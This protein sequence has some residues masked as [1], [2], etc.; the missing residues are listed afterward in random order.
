MAPA[1]VLIGH[2]LI[3]PGDESALTAAE[4]QSIASPLSEVRR[5]SG[6]VRIVGRQLLSQLGYEAYTLPKGPSGAPLWPAG[7]VGSFAH[8]ERVAAA[9]I[10]RRRDAETVGID[11]EPAEALPPEMLDLIATP[12]ERS[13]IGDDLCAGRLLFAAKEAVY[14][15]VHP[16]DGAFLEYR[17]IEI[18]L[19]N[20]TAVVCNWRALG[21]RFCRSSHLVVLAWQ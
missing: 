1:G 21:L 12:N 13:M 9:A 17:D 3:A 6:A 4:A 20:R 14:K 11:V 19:T 15:A 7:I 2:R 10:A 5:A 16:L 18:D 8:D